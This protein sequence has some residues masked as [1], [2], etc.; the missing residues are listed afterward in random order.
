M[1]KWSYWSELG[2]QSLS[3]Q[4]CLLLQLEMRWT[5]LHYAVMGGHE[6]VVERLLEKA[7]VRRI[8]INRKDVRACGRL[9]C[10][11]WVWIALTTCGDTETRHN[12]SDAGACVGMRGE[13]WSVVF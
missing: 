7:P 11:G 4:K 2:T 6:S 13:G 5:P 10:V 1:S 9:A 12:P 3:S 8:T